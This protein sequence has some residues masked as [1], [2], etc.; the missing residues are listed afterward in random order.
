M[1]SMDRPPRGATPA[2]AIAALR[3]LV[4]HRPNGLQKGGQ[5]LRV[6]FVTSGTQQVSGWGS[7]SAGLIHE[8][9]G[10]GVEPVLVTPPAPLDPSLLGVEHYPLLKEPFQRPFGSLT[11]LASW[12]PLARLLEDCD[13][14]HCLVEPYLPLVAMATR[15]ETPLVVTAHGTWSVLPLYRAT[16]RWLYRI[17]WKRVDLL[18][19]Q[20]EYTR[21]RLHSWITLPN[22][23]VLPGG[24]R[25][26]D[27]ADTWLDYWSEMGKSNRMVLSVGALKPRKGH[28]VALEAMAE[29]QR[30]IPN[31]HFVIVGAGASGEVGGSLR[32][33]ARI[34]GVGE[35][36]HVLEGVPARQLA[37]MYR[38]SEIFILLPVNVGAR[39]EGLGL[40]YLEAAAA[41]RPSIGTSNCG[42]KEAIIHG[43][44]GYLVGQGDSH[45]AGQALLGLLT[46]TNLRARMGAAA[47]QHAS[48]FDW[49]VV[50][51]RVLERYQGLVGWNR[52]AGCQNP[53]P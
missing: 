21:S 22:H 37:A 41:G 12:R 11:Q 45:A 40:V 42:A 38:R 50:A 32:T 20:S 43:Q 49:R 16:T 3:T 4:Y 39:F 9:I 5:L 34:N 19:C 51:S 52:E 27:S 35:R 10:R 47:R 18:F 30:E 31:L 29:V 13:L 6:G 2:P 44:T 24:V 46:D 26:E 1:A 25:L 17:A 15:P 36:V 33:Q 28:F 7:Y 14:V 48:S 8:L 53:S 23:V